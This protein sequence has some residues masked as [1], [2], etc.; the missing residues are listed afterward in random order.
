[1]L[2]KFIFCVNCTLTQVMI[3][4]K[5][6]HFESQYPTMNEIITLNH[7]VWVYTGAKCKCSLII[8]FS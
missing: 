2:E 6:I 1:M 4:F 7:P 8:F 5:R 3:K